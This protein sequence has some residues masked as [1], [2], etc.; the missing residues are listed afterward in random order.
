MFSFN[1]NFALQYIFVML[2]FFVLTFFCPHI[3]NFFLYIGKI[4][5]QIILSFYLTKKSQKIIKSGIIN[6]FQKA[7]IITGILIFNLK[8]SN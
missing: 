7:I 2:F 8:N 1:I 6:P 5:F 3:T 4:L